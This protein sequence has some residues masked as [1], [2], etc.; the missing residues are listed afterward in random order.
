MLQKS[1]GIIFHTTD[2]SETSII[3]K[4]YTEDFGL[5]SLLV[6]SVRKKNAR[7]R[8]S[9]F[10]PLSL[11]EL[12]FYHKDRGGLQRISEIRNTIPYREIP[13]D[14]IKSS[15][16]LFLNEVLY[17][18]IRE[19]SPN[20][21]LFEFLFNS[22]QLLD[23]ETS[24]GGNF[25]LIFLIKLTRYLG[26]FPHGQYNE[27]SKIF[28]LKEGSFLSAIPI[29]PHFLNDAESLEFSTLLATAGNI[30]GAYNLS[31]DI[32]RKLLD[33]LLEYYRLHIEGF[34]EIRS[35]KILEEVW[36]VSH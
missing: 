34:G 23:V 22:L 9:I 32:K 13:F 25:H 19:E 35:H 5:Q 2:Y 6:N 20:Q 12:V 3:A 16:V 8:S 17:R 14:S 28:D 1:R 15:M 30:E 27:S 21:G 10:Q 36:S 31:H 7:I 24:S 33:K 11:V 29:H 18:S 26:F 4:I